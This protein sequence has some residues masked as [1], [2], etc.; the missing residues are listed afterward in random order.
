[1]HPTKEETRVIKKQLDLLKV[2]LDTMHN[3]YS[4]TLPRV[5][6]GIITALLTVVAAVLGIPLLLHHAYE[7]FGLAKSLASY[8]YKMFHSPVHPALE[9]IQD[10]YDDLEAINKDLECERSREGRLIL[11]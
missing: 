4:T 6:L 10:L 1:M 3:T 5:C 7:P 8:T 2:E 9:I 11:E